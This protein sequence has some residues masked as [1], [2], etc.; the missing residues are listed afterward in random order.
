MTEERD[1]DNNPAQHASRKNTISDGGDPEEE[2]LRTSP[3]HTHVPVV[4]D[5]A[6][7]RPPERRP[8]GLLGVLVGIALVLSLV[9]LGLSLSIIY[10][11]SNAQRA[12]VEGID[13][14]ISAL[15][16]LE[17]EGLHYEYSFQQE[18]PVSS[19]IPIEEEIVIPFSGDF[20]IETTVQV[21]LDAGVLGRFMFDL[22]INTSV[23]VD[24]EVPIR[25]D[26]TFEISTT[27]AFSMVIPIDVRPND[28]QVQ[29][30]VAGVRAWLVELRDSLDTGLRFPLPGD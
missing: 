1:V 23:E 25:V 11:L 29:Q 10:S 6:P 15:D 16:N 19:S 27:L 28:P 14:A 2:E 12:A 30:G 4:I 3:A 13:S 9:S 24:T 26:Q 20:P 5:A 8:V 18:F 17:G 22:P 7:N 21:P